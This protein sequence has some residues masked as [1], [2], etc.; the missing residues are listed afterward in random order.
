MG[1]QVNEPYGITGLLITR[2]GCRRS[3]EVTYPPP[4]VIILPL[5]QRQRFKIEARRFE[6]AEYHF[7]GGPRYSTA[8]Y[9]EV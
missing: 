9:R 7:N 6:L 3:I 2:C 8:T 5:Q 4:L 1:K